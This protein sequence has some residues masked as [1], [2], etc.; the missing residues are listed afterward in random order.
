MRTLLVLTGLLSSCGGGS[1]AAPAQRAST[2][3]ASEPSRRG[4]P[5]AARFELDHPLMRADASPEVDI[6]ARLD[7]RLV[8][9][10]DGAAPF[11]V[12]VTHY[13]GHELEWSI[14]AADGTCFTPTFLPP[15]VPRPGGPP[16]VEQ[17][18]APGEERELVS[19]HGVS[20]YHRCGARDGTWYRVLPAGTYTIVLSDIRVE[21]VDAPISTAPGTLTVR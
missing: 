20:G 19:L 10:N 11:T 8:L 2:D 5:I 1:P 15:P 7:G 18:L 3:S 12:R 21:G 9:R 17:T 13:V 6:D 4:E 14:T 16:I